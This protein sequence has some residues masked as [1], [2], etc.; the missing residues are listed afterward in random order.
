MTT[1]NSDSILDSTK[2]NLGLAPEIEVFD[3]DVITH[4]NSAFGVLRQLG[5]GPTEPFVIADST[6][7]WADFSS[8]MKKMKVNGRGGLLVTGRSSQLFIFTPV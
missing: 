2:H 1:P 8:D 6:P 7:T 3:T 5:V 4:L